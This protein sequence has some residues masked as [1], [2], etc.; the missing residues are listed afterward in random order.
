[1]QKIKISTQYIK[2]SQFLKL[3]NITSQGSDAKILISEGMIKVNGKTVYQRGKKLY[4][5]DKIE[6]SQGGS[7]EV[8]T[9]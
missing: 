4:N 6:Y 8:I 9:N 5:G 1:M 7:F 3:A 2:L